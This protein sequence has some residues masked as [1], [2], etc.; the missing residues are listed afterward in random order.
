MGFIRKI[1]SGTRKIRKTVHRG[2]SI[3]RGAKKAAPLAKTRKAKKVATTARASVAKKKTKASKVGRGVKR[4]V[5]GR[6][7]Y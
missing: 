4:A 5:T 3:Q 6:R 1:K 7:K 2:K